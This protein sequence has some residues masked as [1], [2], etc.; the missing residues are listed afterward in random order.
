ML[1]SEMHTGVFW[2]YKLDQV[3]FWSTTVLFHLYT[4]LP[5]LSD[6]GWWIFVQEIIV[7][8]ALLALLITANLNVLIPR[9]A[10]AG[11]WPAYGGW[12][13]CAFLLYATVK[14]LHDL[15]LT[16][17]GSQTG[18]IHQAF[19]NTSIAIFY[20][21]FSVAIVLSREWYAQREQLR[22]IA[23]DQVNTELAY[24]R[25]QINPHFLFNSINT[26]Y[27]Q[28]DK[29]NHTARQMLSVFSDMLRYQLYEC[30]EGLI[31]IEKEVEY[32]R[33]Y[34]EL[35]RMRKDE[36]YKISFYAGP[37]LRGFRIAPLLL[38]P[39]V[40]NAFK[41]ISH[42]P[43]GNSID[44]ELRFSEGMFRLNVVNSTEPAGRAV[45]G[46]GLRNVRR[47]LDLLYPGQH[48]LLLQHGDGWYRVQLAIRLREEQPLSRPGYAHVVNPIIS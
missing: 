46:I 26:I 48:E 5:L 9:L 10:R 11:R 27:F 12:L 22:Q 29:E 28:I 34:V 31:P 2:K 44:I 41:H 23:F 47:R 13:L 38:L 36:H 20:V 3:L 35:Q 18:F 37:G 43:D 14:S 17:A 45:G 25:A 4:R 33:N 7:R 6:Y 19:Y 24:L 21:S 32:L 16:D 42:S 8:N 1:S 15:Q 40:E 39:F 30:N